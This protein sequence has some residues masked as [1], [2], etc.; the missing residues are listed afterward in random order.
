MA[1]ISV[2][3]SSD[4]V[5][6]SFSLTSLQLCLYWAISKQNKWINKTLLRVYMSALFSFQFSKHKYFLYLKMPDVAAVRV[7]LIIMRRSK[8]T[9]RSAWVWRS[10]GC[11]QAKYRTQSPPVGVGGTG[12]RVAH[13]KM[14]LTIYGSSEPLEGTQEFC[15]R[16]VECWAGG[17][18]WSN[19]RTEQMFLTCALFFWCFM[20]EDPSKRYVQRR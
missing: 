17:N 6:I 10:P 9:V 19:E 16:E 8:I 4:A 20:V 18:S 11:A 2:Q 12:G 3:T 1:I 5:Q 13:T 14:C 15:S 7:T